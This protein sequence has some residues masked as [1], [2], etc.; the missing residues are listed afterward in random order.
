MVLVL[1]ATRMSM[2]LS[3][4]RERWQWFTYHYFIATSRATHIVKLPA[5]VYTSFCSATTSILAQQS[6]CHFVQR[7][8]LPQRVNLDDRWVAS[9]FHVL[10][11]LLSSL[12]TN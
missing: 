10:C 5:Q 6:W 11:D 9:R 8:I 3:I 7:L 2:C 12:S 1:E 4:K